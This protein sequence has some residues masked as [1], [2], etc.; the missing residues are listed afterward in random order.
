KINESAA[1]AAAQDFA[2][3]T[4][5]M[6]AFRQLYAA[7]R[8]LRNS[9]GISAALDLI[10]EARKASDE[11]L[12]VPVLTMAVQADEFR[13]LRARAIASGNVPDVAEAPH[14]VLASI[15]NGRLEDLHGW[16]LFNQ[17]KYPEA[18]THLKQAS[19]MLPAETPAWRAALWH[20]GV[21]LEQSGQ[22]EQALEAYIK[23]YRGAPPES[24]RRSVIEQ[25]Y[26]SVKGSLEGLDERIGAGAAPAGAGAPNS[27]TSATATTPELAPAETP[28]SEVAP[29]PTPTPDSSPAPDSSRPMS[30][31]ALKN[32]GSRLRSNVKIT[33]RIF[34]SN[35]VG[36]ANVVV[37]LIS[38]SGTVLASTTDNEGNYSFTVAPSQKT[39]RVIPSK[40]GYTF[41]PMDRVFSG[42]FED[43][44]EIDFLGSKP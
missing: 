10:I 15:L 3:G 14:N 9:V 19:E 40:D 38:P 31:E 32:V 37:V 12:K 30:E 29:T 4:D 5:S 39:Y 42:L 18:I 36:L 44:K 8:L 22:K 6:R 7:S 13:E 25:L 34:D 11:A 21:A 2:S 1:I 17:E 20:L 26:R 33:G 28:K 23:S 16:A 35:K 43:Q 27:S 24:V 41:A